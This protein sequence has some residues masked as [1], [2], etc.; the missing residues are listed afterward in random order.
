[1]KKQVN[2]ARPIFLLLLVLTI[3][4]MAAVF[5]VTSSVFVPVTLAMLISLVFEPLIVTWNQKFKIP[6]V[7]CILILL[8]LVIISV[9]VIGSLLLTS[10]KTIVDLYPK[11]EERFMTIYKTI[12]DIFVL[13]YNADDSLFQ[14]L[15]SQLGVRQALQ[16]YAFSLSNSLI[17]FL[18]DLMLVTLFSLFF[19]FDLRYLRQRLEYAFEGSSKGKLTVMITDIIQQVTR[20]MSVKFFISL[21]TG[22]IV[23]GG[24]IAVGMD[25]PVLWGFLAFILNF[26]PNFGS[27]ISGLLTSVFAL[28]QFWPHPAPVIFVALL[29]IGVNFI[30][31]NFL[32][33]KIQGRNLGLSPFVIIVSLSFWGWL[34][35]F[36]GL[37]VA[38]PMM[39]I[40]KIVCE[41]VSILYPLAIL[42]G[43]STQ[44]VTVDPQPAADNTVPNSAETGEK[45]GPLQNE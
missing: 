4:V 39:V 13:P 28:V 18:K 16:N 23:L 14:N 3:I 12:A 32:E 19:L 38:V 43:N 45:N 44:P 25:F 26:I 31:G 35:G 30:L 10:I 17:G 15:W 20:Y 29:M 9:G 34:W 41:N 21:L 36:T 37:I 42:M 24:T 33:P 1:M 7:I 22:L 6:W 40:L 11:Y 5:K 8:T 2:F 27:I